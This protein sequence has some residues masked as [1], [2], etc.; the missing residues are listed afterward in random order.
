MKIGLERVKDDSRYG[1]PERHIKG[2]IKAS[3]SSNMPIGIR[4]VSRYAKY[5][6]TEGNPT[7]PFSVK[8]KSAN[9]GIAAGLIPIAPEYGR[10]LPKDYGRHEKMLQHAYESDSTLK[11]I[12]LTLSKQRL[13]E[14]QAFFPDDMTFSD[15][16]D[17]RTGYALSWKKNDETLSAYAIADASGENFSIVNATGDPILVLGKEIDGVVKPITADYD[18]LVVCPSY[19]TFDPGHSD[20]S[21]FRTQGIRASDSKINQ[22]IVM[23]SERSDVGPHESATMGNVSPRLESVIETINRTIAKEDP[24]RRDPDTKTVH[25]NA[26]LSNPFADD[27]T[28]NVPSLFVF[29][30]AMNLSLIS[31]LAA[32]HPGESLQE[33]HVVLIESVKDMQLIRRH[34]QEQGYYWSS[35]AKYTNTLAPFKVEAVAAAEEGALKAIERTQNYKDALRKI[36]TISEAESAPDLEKAPSSEEH[37]RGP[38]R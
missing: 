14:L 7:K 26:E 36:A 6:L 17:G 33:V 35:H 31:E 25:H 19:E 24:L 37:S 28:N 5:F 18:L 15:L 13:D 9:T 32:H 12:E 38:T 4:P 23:D 27:L 20:K 29:P 30:K 22:A 1:M 8:N 2:L 21:P 34:L 3:E 16:S 10:S 11:P